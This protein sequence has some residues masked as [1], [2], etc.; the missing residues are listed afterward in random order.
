V[1]GL[2]SEHVLKLTTEQRKELAASMVAPMRCGGC[3]YDEQGRRFYVHG[4]RRLLEDGPE[5]QKLL[6]K[7]GWV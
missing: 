2:A 4:G 5:Y 6:R 1:S 7:H 3:D